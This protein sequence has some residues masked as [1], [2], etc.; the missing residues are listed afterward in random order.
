M[1]AFP[2]LFVTDLDGTALGGEYQPYARFPDPFSA[3]LDRLV[4]RGCRWAIN[5]T[6]DVNGQH[7]LVLTSAVKSRP[8]YFIAE[9][10]CRMATLV[11]GKL[12]FV[13]P[14]TA[15]M[16]ALVLQACHEEL[17]S[18]M[19]GVCGNFAPHRMNFY[20][21]W[22]DFTALEPD[23]E[24]LGQY[25]RE[26]H[27]HAGEKLHLHVGGGVVAYP[28]VLQKG[29]GVR[30]AMRRM[31]VAPEEVVIA[32]DSFHGDGSMMNA[33]IGRWG[34]C[35]SNADDN[36]KAHVRGLG[37][38]VGE[39]IASVGIIDAFEKLARRNGWEF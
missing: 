18:L 35:P 21:H 34:V 4:A 12:E 23:R 6:W 28:K 22:F 27:P 13:Q 26:N 3:F 39:G 14:Y 32:G 2:K 7:Q 11:D 37:G 8:S 15:D 25:V 36:L 16:E 1:S 5:T 38:E 31:G 10:S 17:Y 29:N 30:E 19:K 24:R 33:Q 9:M 20:G